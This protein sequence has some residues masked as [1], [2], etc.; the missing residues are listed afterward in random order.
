M[1]RIVVIVTVIAV[2][3]FVNVVVAQRERLLEHG[4][5]VRLELAPVDP[6]SLMQGDYM[7]LDY[8]VARDG[9]ASLVAAGARTGAMVLA[10]DDRGVGRFLRRDDGA[11]LASGETRMRYRLQSDDVRLATHAW[12]FEEG[13]GEAFAKARYGEFRVAPDGVALLTRMLDADLRPLGAS[14]HD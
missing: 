5:I 7:A 9:R 12:F 4:R 6:R 14:S 10:V 8:Q 3:A 1:R 13:K 2:L 11:S